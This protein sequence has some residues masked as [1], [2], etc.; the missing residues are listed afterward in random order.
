MWRWYSLA[1]SSDDDAVFVGGC[2]RSG[3]TLVQE[4]INRHPRIA[5]GPETSMFGLPFNVGNIAPVWQLDDQELG[6]QAES[7][8]HLTEFAS[9]F[10]RRFLLEPSGKQRWADKTPNNVRVVSDLL[11]WYPHGRFVHVLRDGRDV[12]CSLRHHP[13]ERVIDGRVVPVESNNP[14]DRCAR[15]W[16]HDV[17]LGRAFAGHPRYVE[18]RYERLVEDPAGQLQRLCEFLG[19]DYSPQ[20]LDP[21]AS[22][23]QMEQ[24][25]LMNNRNAGSSISSRSIGRWKKDLAAKEKKIVKRI[26]GEMLITTGYADNHDW[27]EQA[28]TTEST[29]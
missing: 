27:V 6:E 1:Q 8:A 10:Y 16:L 20:M 5:C 25:R 21:A 3:T 28:A 7:A 9:W 22:D 24:G 13:R 11:T 14:M 12:V 26:I 29:T 19:E 17:S 23:G 15:R 18:V 4:I 2:G